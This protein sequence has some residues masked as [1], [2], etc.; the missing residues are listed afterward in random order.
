MPYAQHKACVREGSL[1]AR[2]AQADRELK[3]LEEIKEGKTTHSKKLAGQGKRD[4]SVA[5]SDPQ[6]P[7][8]V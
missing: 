8:W 2:K 6:P 4:R 3:A 1:A 7:Q 5:H